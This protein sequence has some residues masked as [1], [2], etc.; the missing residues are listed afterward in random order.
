MYTGVRLP[1]ELFPHRKNSLGATLPAKEILLGVTEDNWSL[2][3]LFTGGHNYSMVFDKADIYGCLLVVK[4]SQTMAF[5][6][7]PILFQLPNRS[8]ES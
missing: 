7:L 4:R 2:A 5:I 3:I 6:M 8:V 1:Y